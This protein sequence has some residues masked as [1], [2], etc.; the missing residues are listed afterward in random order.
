[1]LNLPAAAAFERRIPK[2]KFYTNLSVTPE[3]RRCFTE[4]IESITWADKLAPQTMNLAA[5]QRVQEIE[6]FRIRLTGDTLDD[7]VTELMDKQIPYHILFVLTRPDGKI[8]LL[9]NYKEAAPGGGF[10]LRQRYATSWLA[11]DAVALPL[12]AADMDA[13]YEGFVRYIAGDTLQASV[14]EDLAESVQRTEALNRLQR[15]IDR[16][17]AKMKREKQLP[18]QM[19]LRKKIKELQQEADQWKS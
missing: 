3:L 18:R 17:T 4:Q 15:E 5:G 6:V 16:L 10:T 12:L 7:K 8:R 11:P 2:Q 1:M 13:L 14:G 19:E 9:M